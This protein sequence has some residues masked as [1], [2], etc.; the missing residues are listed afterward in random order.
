MAKKAEVT[1]VRE[2]AAYEEIDVAVSQR[3]P[4][5]LPLTVP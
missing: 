5:Q 3:N 2:A 4:P 1:D